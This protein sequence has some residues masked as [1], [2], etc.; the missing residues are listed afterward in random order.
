MGK[1]TF[2]IPY[3]TLAGV[4]KSTLQEHEEDEWEFETILFTGVRSIAGSKIDTDVIIA[5]GATAAALKLRLPDTPVVELQVSG[6]DIMR[7]VKACT[8]QFGEHVIGVVG[9]P[10]MIYG[11]KSIENI[12]DVELVTVGVRDESE[13]EKSISGLK[14]KGI[15]T[16]L[17]GVMST[18]I[19]QRLGM[20]SL[21]IETGQEAIYQSLLEAKRVA[22]VRRQEQERARQFWAIL[23]YSNDGIVAV[24]AQGKITLVNSVAVNLTKLR[25]DSIGKSIEATLPQLK[26]G[27][28]L[29]SKKTE[30]GEV[31]VV[32]QQQMA[33]NRVPIMIGD[34][35]TGAV[36]TFKPVADIQ[37]LEGKI[38]EKIHRRGH[39]AKMAFTDIIGK[40]SAITEVVTTALEFSKVNSNVLIVGETGT[41]KEVF[42]QSIHNAGQR[43]KG[44]FVAVNCAALPENL[45]ESELF[46]Y[47]EGAFTGAVRGGKMG[48]FELAHRGTIFL[49]EISEIPAKLQGRL[50][51]VLQEREIMRLGDDRVIPI[52]VRIIAATNKDLYQLMQEGSFRK[53]LY[54]RLDI[55]KLAIPPLRERKED[56]IPM[57]NH[58]LQFYSIKCS[59]EYKGITPSAQARL[60]DYAWPGNVRELRNIAERLAVLAKSNVIDERCVAATLVNPCEENRIDKDAPY[61]DDLSTECVMR[62]LEA[63]KYH[64]GK[65]ATLL[66]ISRTTLWRRLKQAEIRKT[67]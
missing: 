31:E 34:E 44:P 2:V 60:L 17:G 15:K 33:V 20:N 30:I 57:I 39:V 27:K 1:I 13:A 47:T 8:T 64:Y 49:D 52:D 7:T 3:P 11:V 5:R 62:A 63:T 58:F 23:H 55:L 67:T 28:V 37:A 10:N 4:V 29:R 12:M 36:A 59:K 45:L 16:I 24:N 61:C 51:R 65:A 35:V 66:G 9:H 21:F 6:Y 14:M 53:D 26:L 46:G 32:H 19:A 43:S 56:I 25:D 22:A 42:S 50:L 38:R 48:L 18:E 54:Y 41:G 40:S